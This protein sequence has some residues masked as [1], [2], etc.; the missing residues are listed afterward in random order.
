MS[1]NQSQPESDICHL[2]NNFTLEKKKQQKKVSNFTCYSSLKNKL[3]Q[4]KLRTIRIL[5]CPIKEVPAEPGVPKSSA[6]RRRIVDHSCSVD[7][8]AKTVRPPVQSHGRILRVHRHLKRWTFF[9]DSSFGCGSSHS[10]QVTKIIAFISAG[11]SEEKSRGDNR[12]TKKEFATHDASNKCSDIS[13]AFF[14]C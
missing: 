4:R 1:E 8:N 9:F 2:F 14:P 10:N 6:T 11:M 12:Q 7:E 5:I 3:N 13:R